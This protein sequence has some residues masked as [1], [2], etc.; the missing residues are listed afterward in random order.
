MQ[1]I[2]F[3]VAGQKLQGTLIYPEKI[4]AKN[5][6]ILFLHGWRSSEQYL[7]A[8]A[9]GLAKLGFVCLTFNMRGSAT[10]EGDI[11]KLTRQDFLQDALTAYDYLANL[12]EV[13]KEKISV[14]GS[15]FGAYLACLLSGKR[16]IRNLVL[17]V[18][19]NYPDEGFDKPQIDF[20]G[21]NN[22]D[23]LRWRFNSLTKEKTLA[24][25]VLHNFSGNILIVESEK[26]ELIP[27]QTIESYINAVRDKSQLTHTVMEGADHAMHD[28]NF[29]LL[30]NEI[31][32]KWFKD[33]M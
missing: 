1:K 25:K 26:D 24:L 15:S 7:L 30:Y 33:K 5:P 2:S 12:K 23:V 8:R 22:P 29:L 32:I 10:S 13:D 19:A 27:H 28:E 6:A 20:S 3:I 11:T 4:R 18:P 9:E 21:D 14:I 17:R 16:N 31:L